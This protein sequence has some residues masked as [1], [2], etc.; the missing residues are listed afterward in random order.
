MTGKVRG[1][2]GSPRIEAVMSDVDSTCGSALMLG[3]QNF[4]QDR[5]PT[6]HCYQRP[7]RRHCDHIEPCTA[8]RRVRYHAPHY[9]RSSR[10]SS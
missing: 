10:C 4:G 6:P 2:N 7:Y 9:T 1:K 8:P 3:S 5:T